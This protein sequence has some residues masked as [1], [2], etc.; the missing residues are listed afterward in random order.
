VASG[1]GGANVSVTVNGIGGRDLAN[2]I[3]GKVVEGIRDYKRRE[4]FY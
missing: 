3:E 4:K 2:L 1:T